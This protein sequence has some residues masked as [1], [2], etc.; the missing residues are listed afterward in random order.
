MGSA[1]GVGQPLPCAAFCTGSPSPLPLCRPPSS[2]RARLRLSAR[3][4]LLLLHL[5]L[6]RRHLRAQRLQPAL[7][8][9][10]LRLGRRLGRLDGLCC[11]LLGS[12]AAARQGGGRRGRAQGRAAQQWQGQAG[13]G[14]GDGGLGG[15]GGSC[16]GSRLQSS[17]WCGVGGQLSRAANVLDSHGGWAS[18]RVAATAGGGTAAHLLAGDASHPSRSQQLQG[19]F[20]DGAPGCRLG[21]FIARLI[22]HDGLAGCRA[23]DGTLS[24]ARCYPIGRKPGQC[25]AEHGVLFHTSLRCVPLD[26]L[27]GRMAMH[28]ALE[29]ARD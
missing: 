28:R 21:V 7:R 23:G 11:P 9:A 12:L 24:M 15:L 5:L 16:C 10:L 1:G 22:P 20:Q 6:H 13:V 8:L 3:L 2:P 18:A 14:G 4:P 17:D 29:H 19:V 26:C 27:D 25:R